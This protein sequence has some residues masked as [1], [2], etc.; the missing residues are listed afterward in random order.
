MTPR[1]TS[2][3]SSPTSPGRALPPSSGPLGHAPDHVRPPRPGPD[4]K[5]PDVHGHHCHGLPAT[6]ADSRLTCPRRS[7]GRAPRPGRTARDRARPAPTAALARPTSTARSASVR[8]HCRATRRRDVR[9][10]VGPAADRRAPRP[11]RDSSRAG[12]RR[13]P[14]AASP[15]ASRRATATSAGRSPRSR[16]SASPTCRSWSRPACSGA[17]SAARSPLLGT[18]APRPPTCRASWTGDAAGL[19]RDD[20]DRATAATCRACSTTATYDPATDEIVVTPRTVPRRKD[21][22]GNAA[23]D[24]RMAAVFAQLVVGGEPRR[25]ALPSS[26]RSATTTARPARGVTIEDCGPKAGLDGVDNG[27]LPSTTS[28][29]RAPTCSTATATSPTT[30]PTSSPIENPE[31]PL[32]HHARHARPRAVS[33]AAR[34]G[35][36]R[37][38]A[39]PSPSRR[40]VPGAASSPRPAPTGRS[41]V[42]DYRDLPAASCCR[43]SRRHT[44]SSSPSTSSSPRCDDVLAGPA[45]G[46]EEDQRR[47]RDP[48]R[49]DQGADDPARD[50]HHPGVPRGVRRRG[51]PLGQPARRAQGRHRHLHDLRGRQHRAAPAR[52]QVACSPTTRRRSATSTRWASCASAP[53]GRRHGHRAHVG[54]GLVQRLVDAAPGRERGRHVSASAAPSCV[55]CAT[56][57]STC[58]EGLAR[59][60][61]A[62]RPLP[63]PTRSRS[64]TRRRT[65]SSTRPC[66]HVERTVAETFA[67]VGR[68]LRRRRRPARCSTRVCDLYALSTIERRQGVVP[69]A[70]PAEPCAR[71][72]AHRPR[73]RGL[74][75]AAPARHDARRRLRHPRGPADDGDVGTA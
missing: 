73:Q 6:D 51:L 56:A 58:I 32:L 3:P 75:G 44:P 64:S 60:L 35:G 63:G 19:L 61:R 13:T 53:A 72:G 40:R 23:R 33:S 7:P 30:A 11:R 9:T 45:R 62:G 39:R 34:R 4:R 1:A 10:A 27:R 31:P 59:R 38:R 49:R 8:D 71:Q 41:T 52:R 25:R 37:G 17:C 42:L 67:A 26:S 5:A 68:V 54:A 43:G 36:R 16:C 21:Y 12:R 24:G 14:R 48:G 50:R 65:T 57:R 66:A 74:L 15:S 20:R 69:R 55:C 29:C 18:P 28:G 70:R 46:H 22:I 47:A 2:R